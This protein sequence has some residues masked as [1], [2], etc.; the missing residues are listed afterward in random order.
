M[1]MDRRFPQV[2]STA[3]KKIVVN[4]GSLFS[5]VNSHPHL[6]SCDTERGSGLSLRRPGPGA[7]RLR[8]LAEGSAFRSGSDSTG[9]R[10][11]TPPEARGSSAPGTRSQG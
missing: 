10:H 5:L 1:R 9:R 4:L 8:L 11:L 3:S 6:P 7:G 2:V